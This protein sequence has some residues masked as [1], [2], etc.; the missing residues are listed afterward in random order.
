MSKLSGSRSRPRSAA[1]DV[2]STRKVKGSHLASALRSSLTAEP[3]SEWAGPWGGGEPASILGFSREGG[4]DPLSCGCGA[5]PG[6]RSPALQFSPG[7][8]EWPA[9]LR[10]LSWQVSEALPVSSDQEDGRST[11]HST[12]WASALPGATDVGAGPLL[13]RGSMPCTATLGQ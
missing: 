12:G 9:A 3:V 8:T 1:S 13:P 10:G 11:P 5:D 7:L 4:P 6:D 2:A